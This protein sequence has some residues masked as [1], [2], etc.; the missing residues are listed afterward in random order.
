MNHR[1]KLKMKTK[2]LDEL[3]YVQQSEKI[4]ESHLQ[5]KNRISQSKKEFLK[6]IKTW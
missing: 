4:L 2:K 1:F 3:Q 6:V 5:K